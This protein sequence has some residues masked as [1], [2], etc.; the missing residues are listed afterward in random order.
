MNGASI[1]WLSTIVVSTGRPWPPPMRR[2]SSS[3]G[4]RTETWMPGRPRYSWWAGGISRTTKRNCASIRAASA[5]SGTPRAMRSGVSA[6]KCGASWRTSP[7]SSADASRLRMSRRALCRSARPFGSIV[8]MG[9][10]MLHQPRPV[11]KPRTALLES[12]KVPR[13]LRDIVRFEVRYPGAGEPHEVELSG[14][15]AVLGRD[16]SCDLVLNDARC[17]RR[18]AVVEAGPQGISIRDAGSAN[19]IY[20]NGKKVERSALASA[21]VIRLGEVS[22]K[23]LPEEVPGTVVMAPEDLE[24]MEVMHGP[25]DG[26]RTASVPPGGIPS[27]SAAGTAPAPA[28]AAISP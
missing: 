6:K 3:E 16:P 1:V 28:L 15:V 24:S 11:P 19:G 21:D 25:V 17:S 7:R 14:T 5:G 10:A 8:I 23:V 26:S 2:A 20:V 9:R 13:T 27:R 12:S 4:L 22:I 18:H